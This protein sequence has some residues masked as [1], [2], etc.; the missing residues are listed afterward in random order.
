VLLERTLEHGVDKVI[1]L[2][3]NVIESFYLDIPENI[4]EHDRL[5]LHAAKSLF[6]DTFDG[7]R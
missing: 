6:K 2:R 7:I 1:N 3:K 4:D 5:N